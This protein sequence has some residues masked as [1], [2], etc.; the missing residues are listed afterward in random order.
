MNYGFD[1]ERGDYKPYVH[2]HLAY[3]FEI[4]SILGKGSFGQA[5]CPA[6]AACALARE[7]E[8]SWSMRALPCCLLSISALTD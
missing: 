2:D 5:R 1:D 6:D 4:L 3:Q 7:F 8:S